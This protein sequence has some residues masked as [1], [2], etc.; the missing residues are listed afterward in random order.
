[1]SGIVAFAA[2][3]PPPFLT[4]SVFAAGMVIGAGFAIW[5]ARVVEHPGGAP[6]A[7][8]HTGE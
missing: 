7:P 5:R 8:P 3:L 6:L 4:L 2:T 1:M